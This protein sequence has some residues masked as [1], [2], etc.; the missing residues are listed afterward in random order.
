[1][2]LSVTTKE[3]GAQPMLA[4]RATSAM[5]KLEGLMG[6]LFGE[7]YGYIQESGE[8]PTGMP[9]SRYHS[10]DGATVDLECGM[11]V[12]SPMDGKGRVEAGE[13]PAGTV[14]TVTHLGPYNNL[15]QSWSALTEWMGS[16]G[17]EPAGAPWE[18]YVT[19]PGAEPDQSKWRTDIFFPVR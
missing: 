14:A 6:S 2:K 7:V 13:L 10:M 5:D 1:M 9:F 17:L 18:V 3:I 4:I 19:D 11:P 12:A 15:P 8:Q 16:Q